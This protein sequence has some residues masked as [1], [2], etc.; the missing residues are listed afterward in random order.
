MFACCLL[1]SRIKN[2]LPDLAEYCSNVLLPY[3]GAGAKKRAN[4]ALLSTI[5]LII[6]VLHFPVVT[7]YDPLIAASLPCCLPVVVG[8]AD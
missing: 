4:G 2:G 6:N 3:F 7:L 8:I 1:E 5:L